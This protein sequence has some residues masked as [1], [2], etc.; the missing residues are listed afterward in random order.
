MQPHSLPSM[1]LSQKVIQSTLGLEGKP[2]PESDTSC[3]QLFINIEWR[4]LREWDWSSSS[5]RFL[6]LENQMV[7]RLGVRNPPFG[8]DTRLGQS[9]ISKASRYA[10][11]FSIPSCIERDCRFA[12]SQIERNLSSR[13]KSNGRNIRESQLLPIHKCYRSENWCVLFALRWNSNF[14]QFWI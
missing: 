13:K 9:L 12:Q 6:Q 2:P 3:G 14:L 10:R 5:L 1:S 11:S 7:V 8:K 4:E